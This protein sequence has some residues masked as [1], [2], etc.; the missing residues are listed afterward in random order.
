[1]VTAPELITSLAPC[2]MNNNGIMAAMMKGLK[3]LAHDTDCGILIV[4]HTRKGVDAE[5]DAETL[6][7]RLEVD[8]RRLATDG[9]DDERVDVTDDRSVVLFDIATLRQFDRKTVAA[10]LA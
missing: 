10:V 2:G 9:V 4:A 5:T 7:E 3:A 1:M 6:F 8:V